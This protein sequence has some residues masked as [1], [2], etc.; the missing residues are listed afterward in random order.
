MTSA[1][2]S[3]ENHQA[4]FTMEFTAEDFEA[5]IDKVYRAQRANIQVDGFRKGKAPRKI[6]ESRYGKGVFFEDAIDELFKE[7]YPNAL[8]QHDLVP[9]DQ[10][11]V[12]FGDE[13]LEQ[14]KG[15]AVTVTVT[16]KPDIE[17]KEYKGMKVD[18]P[19][20]V[21]TDEDIN[22][23]LHDAQ[24]RA[25]RLENTEN[26]AENGDTVILDYKGFCDDKQ[27]EGGTAD[28]YSLELGSHRFIPGFEDALIG[29]K[30]GED[31][32][33]NV[34]FPE[35]YPVKELAG[36]PAVFKCTVH[37]V[38]HLDLPELDDEFAADVSDFDTLEEYKA[39]IRKRREEAAEK[40]KER[41]ARNVV[42]EK[43]CELNPVDIPE[44]M[45]K[46]EANNMLEDFAQQLKAQGMTLEQY[47]QYANCTR[48][49]MAAELYPEAQKRIHE[50]LIKEAVVKAENIEVSQEEIDKE[51]MDMAQAYDMEIA[52]LQAALSDGSMKYMIADMKARK[53]IDF[54]VENAVI[55]DVPDNLP[56]KEEA[57]K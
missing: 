56:K 37:E 6:I 2:I 29:I 26:P 55:T 57:D 30:A 1:F 5:A 32:D 4:K 7:G 28:N 13:K 33:V 10:P 24:K 31:R 36:K 48:E 39:D 14:G 43:A 3:K 38:K 12:E 19:Y 44:A 27:F 8:D 18:R 23:E 47:C 42:M 45:W 11:S 46:N 50:D 21:V 41:T 40:A 20:H 16:V 15:F 25:G 52:E 17:L 51:L 9:V 34:T 49:D 22:T 54:M 53:A 35:D